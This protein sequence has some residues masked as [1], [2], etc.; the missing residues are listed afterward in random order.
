MS[1]VQTA[2]L[3]G[4]LEA[5]RGDLRRFL[6]ARTGSEADADDL[7]SELWIKANSVQ[8]GP[9]SNPG[10]YLFKMANNL[11]LDRLRETSRRQRRE[12]D[13]IAEQRGSH[14]LVEEPADPASSAEQML[15]ERDEQNRLTEAIDHLPARARRVLRMHKLEG[16]GH[17]E[18]AAQLG[19]SK[20]AVEKHMALAMAHLRRILTTEAEPGPRRLEINKGGPAE[21]GKDLKS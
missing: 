16:L 14:A 11:V 17:A 5:R 4:T 1:L 15:I 18:I 21:G 12:G 10:S 9:V 6:I 2:G 13:W 20:S 7:L 19:I 3:T 8:P